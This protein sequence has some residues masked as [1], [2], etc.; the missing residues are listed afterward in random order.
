MDATCQINWKLG[1]YVASLFSLKQLHVSPEMFILH[2]LL[3]T[4][5]I[6]MLSVV[7]LMVPLVMLKFSSFA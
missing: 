7:G 3:P 6:I 2:R 5:V 4:W 1:F